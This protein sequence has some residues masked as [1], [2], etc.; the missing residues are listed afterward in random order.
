MPE[1]SDGGQPRYIRYQ[2]PVPDE[3]GR[4]IGVFGLTNMLGRR[5]RLSAA[6]E[7]FRVEAN[8]WY[9]A[10]Y[11]NPSTIDP[12]VYDESIHPI[13]AAWFKTSATHLI[14]R[15][16]RYLELLKRYEVPCVRLETDSVPG[17]VIYE[18]EF[19]VVVVPR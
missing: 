6:D 7:K 19:Q 10:A 14:A 4:H 18:D 8:A 2:S 11:T 12:R 15:V 13:T 1:Q 17:R 16:D 5:G 9:D 3:R